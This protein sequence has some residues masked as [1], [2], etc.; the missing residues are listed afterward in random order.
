MEAEA[1][2]V[3]DSPNPNVASC[4]VLI[5][6]RSAPTVPDPASTYPSALK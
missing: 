5:G 2:N 3:S 4:P 1:E 6:R